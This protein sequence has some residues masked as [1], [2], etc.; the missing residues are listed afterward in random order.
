[1]AVGDDVQEAPGVLHVVGVAG[2]DGFP[3]VAGWIGGGLAEGGQ[4][5][6]LAVG[7]VIGQRL[8]GPLA[9]DQDAASGVPEVF[10]AVG[11]ALACAGDQA[12]AGVLGLDAVAQPVGAPRRARLVPQRL[13]QL[14]DVS[15]LGV[16]CGLVAVGDVFGEVLG[17]VADAAG[18]VLRP[19]QDA[20]GVEPVPEPGHVQRLILVADGVE[21]LVPGG[22]DFAGGGVEVGAV[23]SSQTGSWSPSKR[24]TEV[25][26]HHTWW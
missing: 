1:M 23:C 6:V 12:G 2:G 9:G 15:P 4:E 7:A 20:L 18:R 25:S 21:G 17:Q 22:Q 24:T 16:A 26:G 14:L 3:G 13:G 19:A 5:P 10:A 11:F 8:A